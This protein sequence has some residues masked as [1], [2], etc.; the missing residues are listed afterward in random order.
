LKA[1]QDD[2]KRMDLPSWVTPAPSS[3]GTG[4][5]GKLTADQWKAV[6]SIN[7]VVTLVRIWGNADEKGR[8]YLM[9]SNFMDLVTAVKLGCK[10]VLELDTVRLYE[11]HMLRYLQGLTTIYAPYQLLPYQ[12]LAMH[13]GENLQ[14]FGP[15]HA[16]RCFVY[17]RENLRL[18]KTVTNQKF[19]K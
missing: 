2:A 4:G 11:E 3:L 9:L 17:E 15:T 1:V 5:L 10:R 7:L 12:H 13:F 8:Q 16:T 19:G 14:R 18:Q 6:C